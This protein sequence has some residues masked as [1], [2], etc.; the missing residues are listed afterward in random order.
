MRIF[1][2]G[3]QVRNPASEEEDP[4][5]DPNQTKKKSKSKQKASQAPPE[6]SR[7]DHTLAEHHEHLLSASFDMSFAGDLSGQGVWS[8][9]A[10]SGFDDNENP[11]QLSDGL[12]IGGDY[13]F[14][15]ELARELGWGSPAKSVGSVARLM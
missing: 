6:I 12:D 14:G 11:F 7:N 15:D 9:H 10:D 2:A 13:N 4:D 1:H 5:F 3:Q 8:S